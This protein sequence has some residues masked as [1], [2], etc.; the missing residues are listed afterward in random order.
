[1]KE[2]WKIV[3]DHLERIGDFGIVINEA[4]PLAS[5]VFKGAISY[6]TAVFCNRLAL[7]LNF[8]LVIFSLNCLLTVPIIFSSES[9]LLSNL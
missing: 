8:S 1:M 5:K 3:Q 9:S 4:E 2:E 6:A 7:S